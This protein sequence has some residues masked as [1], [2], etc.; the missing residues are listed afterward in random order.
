MLS[1]NSNFSFVQKKKDPIKFNKQQNNLKREYAWSH[2]C[3]NRKKTNYDFLIIDKKSSKF[4]PNVDTIKLVLTEINKKCYLKGTI[5]IE[6][7][8]KSISNTIQPIIDN[9]NANLDENFTSNQ[10]ECNIN[11][12]YL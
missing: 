8:I 11:M 5:K 4:I 7:Q 12:Y 6:N 3:C 10:N 9:I 2:Q 1:L